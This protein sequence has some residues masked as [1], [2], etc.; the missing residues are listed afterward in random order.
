[1]RLT[2]RRL[3]ATLALVPAPLL[4]QSAAERAAR[5]ERIV[6]AVQVAGRDTT[7]ALAERLRARRVPGVSV[8]VVD[9]FRVVW[10][11][12][13]GVAEWG[14]A[15]P[16]DTG[17]LFLAGSI[18]KPVTASGALAMVEGGQLALDE[19]VNQRLTSWKVPESAFTATEKVTLRRI[20]SHSAGLTVWGFP[21]YAR[22]SAVPTVVQVL[23]GARPANTKPVRNDTTPGARWMYSGGGYTVAQ[24][25][26]TD[27]AR[28]PFPSLMRRLV[29]GPV[30]MRNSTFEQPL[31]ARLA[32]RA[33]TGHERLDTAVAG[34][35]HTYPEMAA[36]GLW[37]TASDLG[38]WGA[39][40]M[41]AA[42]GD[43]GA[44]ISPA[45]A[46][47]MLTP[48]STPQGAGPNGSFG[49]G[50]ALEGRGDS[51]VFSHNGR[52]EGFVAMMMMWPSRGQ[53]IV[54][55][56]NATN[57]ALLEEIVRSFVATYGL[58]GWSRTTVTAAA[59]APASLDSLVGRYRLPAPATPAAAAVAGTAPRFLTVE[60]RGEALWMVNPVGL[61]RRLVPT[62]PLRFVDLA[63]GVPVAFA[64]GAD[65]GV[66]TLTFGTGPRATVAARER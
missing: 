33:A 32:G 21:G 34:K 16:V 63:D 60:R 23:D 43:A 31:P 7:F 40:M 25:L 5:I 39:A 18:S 58:P 10:A 2:P 30:G 3:I 6:P 65:G 56:T 38:R 35:W 64:R 54:V 24:L 61:P 9:S 28:E 52:D 50:L 44:G 45:V 53:G 47:W 66:E 20:L 36:A 57:G 8:A 22:D 19:D 29:L 62:G 4:A 17:T 51:L 41:R 48:T 12:G 27:V 49:L 37:T 55:M 42:R 14:G 46:S 15:A 59:I 26:M 13:F 1:M 11:R